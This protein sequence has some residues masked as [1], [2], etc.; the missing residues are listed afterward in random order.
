MEPL[1]STAPGEGVDNFAAAGGRVIGAR[2]K[3]GLAVLAKHL[4]SW[5]G[6]G[7]EVTKNLPG[8]LVIWMRGKAQVVGIGFCPFD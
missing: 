8:A 2:H 3:E 4:V 1:R 7:V 5:A 6:G